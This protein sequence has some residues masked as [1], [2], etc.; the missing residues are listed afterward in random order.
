MLSIL[1]KVSE[2]KVFF[3]SVLITSIV[4]GAYMYSTSYIYIAVAFV[5]CLSITAKTPAQSLIPLAIVIPWGAEIWNIAHPRL[6]TIMRLSLVIIFLFKT[7]RSY[8]RVNSVS[9]ILGIIT[10]F[11]YCVIM[12]FVRFPEKADIMMLINICLC[13][14]V[15]FL[16]SRFCSA[17]DYSLI[18]LAFGLGVS[19]SAVI[20]LLSPL[21]PSL[22]YVV[23]QMVKTDNTFGNGD[24]ETGRFSAMT[25][26]PNLFGMFVICALSA[27]LL[28]MKQKNFENSLWFLLTTIVL[29]VFGM[30]T[31]SKTFFLVFIILMLVYIHIVYKDKNISVKTKTVFSFALA[32]IVV[33]GLSE[34]AIYLEAIVGR[35][36]ASTGDISSLTTNR[37]DLWAYYLNYMFDKIDVL[38]FGNSIV[39][40]LGAMSTPHNMIIYCLFYLGIIGCAIFLSMMVSIYKSNKRG[41]TMLQ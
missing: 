26:D 36:T 24:I 40:R 12:E 5:I 35:F 38:I 27:C 41:R 6:Y 21:V 37:S 34:L 22:Y 8:K 16:F 18:S 9:V 4:I 25:Y 19:F 13:F 14:Y 3:I 20:A 31:L 23:Q 11:F 15:V 33:L 1:N 17:S 30:L 2:T 29:T 7:Y 39:G 32:V 10:F 28:A